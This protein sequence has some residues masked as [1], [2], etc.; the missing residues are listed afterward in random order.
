M[1]IRGH[2]LGLKL[3]HGD[4]S[5]TKLLIDQTTFCNDRKIVGLVSMHI[6][7]AGIS[8]LIY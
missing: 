1:S 7:I 6:L 8:V 4:I 2:S 5:N 3:Y